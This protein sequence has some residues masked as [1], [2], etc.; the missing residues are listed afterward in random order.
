ME[1][2]IA[3]LIVAPNK[4]P[5]LGVGDAATRGLGDPPK[6][7]NAGRKVPAA[8]DDGAAPKPPNTEGL[9]PADG[10]DPEANERRG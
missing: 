3:P 10:D 6:P 2:A 7:A 9:D 8:E 1:S 4:K 5:S